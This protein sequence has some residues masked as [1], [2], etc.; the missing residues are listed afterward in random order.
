MTQR[1]GRTSK[2]TDDTRRKILKRLRA[3]VTIAATCDSV[4]IG[5]ST[6]FEWTAIGRAHLDGTT[7][8]RMPRKAAD[9]QVYAEFAEAVT[10]AI[11]DGL[12]RATIAFRQGMSPSKSE[13]TITET[14]KETRL[15]KEG[16]PYLYEKTVTRHTVEQIPGDW[17]AAMEY[18]ARRDPEH[19][20]RSAPQKVEHTGKDGGPIILKTGMSLDE[21]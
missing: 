5:E 1:I 15:D 11:A 3:G 16:N 7:H 19:W 18:L 8:P 10:R 17:R 14:I 20:A 12:V 6:Y 9:R 4:G 2:F 13:S 21:I